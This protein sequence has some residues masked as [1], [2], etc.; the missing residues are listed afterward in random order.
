MGK[1]SA[2]RQSQDQRLYGDRYERMDWG[3]E[4]GGRIENGTEVEWTSQSAGY[5]STKRGKVLAYIPAW[6]SWGLWRGFGPPNH[7]A[8]PA[9]TTWGQMKAGS[10]MS[11]NNRYLVRVDRGGGCKPWIYAP[12][13]ENVHPTKEPKT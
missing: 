7:P 10:N 12:K 4:M 11:K 13:A 9:G 3:S 6:E 2:R 1:G 5:R 8:L